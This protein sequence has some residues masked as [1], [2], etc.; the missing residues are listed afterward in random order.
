M[1][2]TFEVPDDA[3]LKEIHDERYHW[4]Y[5]RY[6]WYDADGI[7]HNVIAESEFIPMES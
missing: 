3:E 1:I 7:Q 5:V 6:R 4:H 2:V